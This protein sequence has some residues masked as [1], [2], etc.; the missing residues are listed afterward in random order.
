VKNFRII[1][2]S[3]GKPPYPVKKPAESPL[4]RSE[5]PR[6]HKETLMWFDLK[7]IGNRGRGKLWGSGVYKRIKVVLGKISS[8]RA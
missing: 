1:R 2:K 6:D 8:S 3:K 5:N 7:G 4:H